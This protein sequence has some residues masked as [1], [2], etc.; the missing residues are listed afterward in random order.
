M[1][2]ETC[3]SIFEGKKIRKIWHNNEWWFSVINIVHILTDSVDSKDYWYRMKKR[4]SEESK[5]ELSTF[6]RQLKLVAEDGKLMKKNLNIY[7]NSSIN[8]KNG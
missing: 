5:I 1:E 8:I 7:W 3:L 6:C 2:K 4:E